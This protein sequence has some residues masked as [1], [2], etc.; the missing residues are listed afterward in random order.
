[1]GEKGKEILIA[2]GFVALSSL[3]FLAVVLSGIAVWNYN[4]ENQEPEQAASGTPKYEYTVVDSG[5]VGDSD[6]AQ[7][8][9]NVENA[10]EV[11]SRDAASTDVI[12]RS[13][14]TG[15]KISIE[16]QILL[17]QSG[18]TITAQEYV[19]DSFWGD[20]IR[21]LTENQSGHNIT[22]GCTALIVNDYM[23]TDLF[24]VN[25]AD[26]KRISP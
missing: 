8:T 22:V 4:R 14:K 12:A 21:I 23:I 18:V 17:Q 15:G 24:A 19:T 20:G 10:D 9:G 2:A 6:I 16:P 3:V 13:G 5:T 7:S 1:M 11:D 25:V 26:G